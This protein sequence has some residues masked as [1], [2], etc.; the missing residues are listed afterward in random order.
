MKIL[1][2]GGKIHWI[3]NIYLR[4][5]NGGGCCD[6]YSLDYYL[7]K[8]I[9]KPLKEFRRVGKIGYPSEFKNMKEWNTVLDKIIWSFEYL[10]D[11]EGINEEFNLE[12]KL[13]ND[14]KEQ[15]GFELFGKYFRN[16]WI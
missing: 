10:L 14:K 15:E 4:Y 2:S 16:L 7:A 1:Q 13:D 11:G 12:K 6:I 5:K 9:I 8:K 3:K